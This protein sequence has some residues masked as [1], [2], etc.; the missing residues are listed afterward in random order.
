MKI[1]SFLAA[2]AAADDNKIESIEDSIGYFQELSIQAV[3]WF[4]REQRHLISMAIGLAVTAVIVLVVHW[5]MRR[6]LLPGA[7]KLPGELPARIVDRLTAPLR[8]LVLRRLASTK[9]FLC[10][11]S[12]L[13]CLAGLA[14]SWP[15]RLT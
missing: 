9:G 4:Q 10:S 1:L 14:Q 2:A 13:G 6:I 7:R 3:E 12:F 5:I 15:I 11:R 8:F